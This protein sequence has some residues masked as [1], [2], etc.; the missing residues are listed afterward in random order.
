MELASS[1]LVNRLIDA[2]GKEGRLPAPE[3][4]AIHRSGHDVRIESG[5]SRVVAVV[6]PRPDARLDALSRREGEVAALIALGLTNRQIA[7]RLIISPA[8]VKDHVHAI[9]SKTGFESRTQL[10]AAWYGGLAGHTTDRCSNEAR[11]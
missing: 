6:R 9:L 7:G 1:V 11:P 5:A 3:I 8:T 2:L 10:I 4:A